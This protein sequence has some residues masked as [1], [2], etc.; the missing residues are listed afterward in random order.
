M[1][2]E[3]KLYQRNSWICGQLCGI[4]NRISLALSQGRHCWNLWDESTYI[5]GVYAGS[6]VR[7]M[8]TS[9]ERHATKIWMKKLAVICSPE[10]PR[11]Q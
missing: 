8:K 3:G 5:V 11:S 2:R 9:S 6:L 10:R 4:W 1:W 7:Y